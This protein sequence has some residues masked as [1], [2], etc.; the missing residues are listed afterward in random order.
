MLVCSEHNPMFRSWFG[1]SLLLMR[2]RKGHRALIKRDLEAPWSKGGSSYQK[3]ELT[4]LERHFTR[5][6]YSSHAWMLNNLQYST[7]RLDILICKSVSQA[8]H[9]FHPI[10]TRVMNQAKTYNSLT[11]RYLH[12]RTTNFIPKV[13]LLQLIARAG[14]IGRGYETIIQHIPLIIAWICKV[15][16][17]TSAF[18]QCLQRLEAQYATIRSFRR[19]DWWPKLF[20]L[21]R[22]MQSSHRRSPWSRKGLSRV[23]CIALSN[24]QE[25]TTHGRWHSTALVKSLSLQAQKPPSFVRWPNIGRSL[26]S[27]MA[28]SFVRHWAAPRAIKNA[29]GQLHDDW[30]QHRWGHLDRLQG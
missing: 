4:E 24:W 9:T 11:E 17:I 8:L 16:H 13:F 3:R 25:V 28:L 23:S 14:V 5:A 19:P 12:G 26:S 2:Q 18:Y 29:F 15:F 6:S 27:K 20:N 30:R 21:D 22:E 7:I 10:R 1:Q